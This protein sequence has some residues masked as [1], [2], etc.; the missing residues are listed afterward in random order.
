MPLVLLLLLMIAGLWDDWP[1][2]FDSVGLPVSRVLAAA[3]TWAGVLLLIGAAAALTKWTTNRLRA[4]P[5]QARPIV[6]AY[7]R[8]RFFLSLAQ[9]TYGGIALFLFGWGWAV[10]NLGP[11]AADGGPRH[12]PGADLLLFMPN[13]VIA[14]FSWFWFYDVEWELHRLHMP[15]EPAP[16]RGRWQYVGF[17][18]RQ[19][20]ALLA[21][22]LALLIVARAVERS[23][24]GTGHEDEFELAVLGILSVAFLLLPWILRLVLRLRPLPTGP[25]RDRLLG[26]S[27]RLGF[28]AN[29]LLVWDT[30]QSMANAMVVG[31]LPW[32]RYIIFTD[33]LVAEMPPAEL[34]AV[35]GHEVG[36]L[37]HRHMVYYLGF[38]LLSLGVLLEL[39]GLARL[40]W[41]SD[42]LPAADRS[43]ANVPFLL[44]LGAYIF[45]VF[46]FLSRRCERQAD[47]FGCRAVSCG[48]PD[49]SGHDERGTVGSANTELCP[50]GIQTFVLALERVAELNG[51]HRRRPGW[52]QSWQH[53]TIA[54]RVSFLEMVQSNPA[55]A[56]CFQRRVR[57]VKWAV[58]V[59]LA[60]LLALLMLNPEARIGLWGA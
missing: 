17:Q 48:R 2:F 34:E 26:L 38:F 43:L 41:L 11:M 7:R 28:R 25:L 27:Q 9:L 4:D 32:L 56:V 31:L 47:L 19:R 53:S 10:E 30:R 42:Y 57:V 58:L 33:R 23:G 49:C 5:S 39:W 40:H 16:F 60:A 15:D 8:R 18:V 22:P 46:G 12:Y 35:L 44:V 14:I 51:L 20:L 36:H 37:K 24:L 21:V 54:R 29:D 50:T 3:L 52:L 1:Q 45:L 59:G 13:L 55:V 6:R